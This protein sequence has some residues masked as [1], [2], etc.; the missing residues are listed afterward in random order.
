MPLALLLSTSALLPVAPQEVFADPIPLSDMLR[1]AWCFSVGDLDQDG[2]PDIVLGGSGLAWVQDPSDPSQVESRVISTRLERIR[3]VVTGDVDGDGL[4]DVVA[5][6]FSPTG[7]CELQWYKAAPGAA[8]FEAQERRALP[9]CPE[10]VRV[11]DVDLDGDGDLVFAT[12]E[13]FSQDQIRWIENVSGQFAGAPQAIFSGIVDNA[14]QSRT[15]RANY[16][17]PDIDGD[18]LRDLVVGGGLFGSMQLLPGLSAGGF[19]AAVVVPGSSGSADR[20]RLRDVDGD[21]DLDVLT[22]FGT[23]LRSQENLGAFTF[24][25]PVPFGPV[26]TRQYLRIGPFGDLDGDGDEDFVVAQPGGGGGA[27]TGLAWCEATG[28]GQWAPP[29]AISPIVS[30]MIDSVRAD[31]DGDGVNDS[32]GFVGGLEVQLGT[33]S[34]GLPDLAPIVSLGEPGLPLQDVIAGDFDG[35]G[36]RDLV[37]STFRETDSVVFLEALGAGV[38]A[39]RQTVELVA[40]GVSLGFSPRFDVADFDGDGRDELFAWGEFTSS[41]G[42]IFAWTGTRFEP[43]PTQPPPFV[44]PTDNNSFPPRAVDVDGDGDVDL[45]GWTSE[46]AAP[47]TLIVRWNDGAA[48]GWT[49][50]SFA[51][52]EAAAVT[53]VDGDGTPDLAAVRHL[54]GGTGLVE[55]RRGLA[56]GTLG[57]PQTIVAGVGTTFLGAGD[58]TGDG[59]EDLLVSGRPDPGGGNPVEL[60][61]LPRTGPGAQFASVAATLLDVAGDEQIPEPSIV[62]LDGDGRLDVAQFLKGSAAPGADGLQLW[63]GLAAGGLAPAEVVA[64]RWFG[65]GG[66]LTDLD[67]DG[68]LDLVQWEFGGDDDESGLWWRPGLARASAGSSFCGPAVPNSTGVSAQMLGFGA[69]STTSQDL[70]LRTIGLPAGVF[71]IYAA[72]RVFGAPVSVPGSAGNLCLRGDIGRYDDPSQLQSSGPGGQFALVLDPTNLEQ[73]NGPVPAMAAETWAFQAWFRDVQGGTPTSN[74]SDALLLEF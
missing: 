30:A 7:G 16:D 65:R 1:E 64:G 35:D 72:S 31:L 39:P 54:A 66:E 24:A 50:Q 52:T 15:G 14:S 29:V 2:K 4:D 41:S 28:A 33:L 61:V 59:L 10:D 47:P 45:L 19:G 26:S 58:F 55:W 49:A 56:P 20:A 18:G 27:F 48:T 69:V 22:T 17:F 60:L 46:A 70:E 3:S 25:G 34:G 32:L 5:V 23:E 51:A 63:R 36:D 42:A 37:A 74:F 62:D 38:F 13:L 67:R 53:D 73:P 21:G 44:A 12:I 43:L 71:G 9:F 40:S 68:D 6:P 11:L 57:P 8:S